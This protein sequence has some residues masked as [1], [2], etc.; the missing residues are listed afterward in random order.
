M[1]R[2]PA[3]RNQSKATPTTLLFQSR[4]MS[5]WVVSAEVLVLRRASVFLQKSKR[6]GPTK[7]VCTLHLSVTRAITTVDEE[8]LVQSKSKVHFYRYYFCR[9][10]HAVRLL[11]LISKLKIQTMFTEN[12]W[13][14]CVSIGKVLVT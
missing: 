3:I 11:R 13:G 5:R 1:T 14:C 12:R 2:V 4:F 10:I 7:A 9:Q 6:Y 8:E